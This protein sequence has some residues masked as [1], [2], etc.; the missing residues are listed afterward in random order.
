MLTE[1]LLANGSGDQTVGAAVTKVLHDACLLLLRD[2][3][4]LGRRLPD[5]GHDTNDGFVCGE[6]IHNLRNAVAVVREDH[7]LRV[8]RVL[9]CGIKD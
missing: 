4:G 8:V 5:K 2:A 6:Q 9:R 1:A 3:L 7:H